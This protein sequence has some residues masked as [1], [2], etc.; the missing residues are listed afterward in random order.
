MQVDP[1]KPT[2]K[3]AE[4]KLLKLKYDAPLSNFALKFNLRRYITA[5]DTSPYGV[6]PAFKRGSSFYSPDYDERAAAR[7]GL[8]LF[9]IS[10]QRK[11]FLLDRGC[12]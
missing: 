12:I 4:N 9:P 11:R 6:D 5:D 2:L 1:V 3:A 8:T 10:A 7:Q